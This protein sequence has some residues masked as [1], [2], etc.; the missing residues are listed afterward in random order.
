MAVFPNNVHAGA[1]GYVHFDGLGIGFAGHEF[2]IAQ[3]IV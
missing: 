3:G 1:G 2:S